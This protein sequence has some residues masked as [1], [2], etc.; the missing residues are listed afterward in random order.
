MEIHRVR[1][2]SVQP[3]TSHGEV[4]ISNNSPLEFLLAFAL[5]FLIGALWGH[6]RCSNADARLKEHAA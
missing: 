3:M 6:L 1:T 5:V 2:A 4:V